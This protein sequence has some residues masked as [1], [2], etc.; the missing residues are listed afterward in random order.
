MS[1]PITCGAAIWTAFG[2]VFTDDSR[3]AFLAGLPQRPVRRA[4]CRAVASTSKMR[5][6]VS[7]RSIVTSVPL[8]GDET[9]RNRPASIDARSRA[10][11]VLPGDRV[12]HHRRPGGGTPPYRLE[13]QG[14]LRSRRPAPAGLYTVPSPKPQRSHME[15]T[16]SCV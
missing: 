12:S 16:P 5:R 14:F 8:P 3:G 15:R 9:T 6:G 4:H 7:G 1:G 11:A 10:L 2:A 13:N